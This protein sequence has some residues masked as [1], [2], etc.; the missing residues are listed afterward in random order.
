MNA[1]VIAL[2]IAWVFVFGIVL[3]RILFLDLPIVAQV[4]AFLEVLF[5]AGEAGER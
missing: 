2:V 4:N 5:P 1:V 3:E